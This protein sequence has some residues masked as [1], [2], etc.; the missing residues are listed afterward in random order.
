MREFDP[1]L[2]KRQKRVV[3]DV[4]NGA[5]IICD[6]EMKGAIIA[7]EGEEGYHINNGVFSRLVDKGWIYQQ[8]CYPFHYILT[9][10]AVEF[11][12]KKREK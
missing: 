5:F 6:S 9:W 2:S 1:R 4:Y 12:K 10:R 7:R 3:E 11:I 8:G